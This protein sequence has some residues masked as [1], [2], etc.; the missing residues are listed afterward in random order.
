MASFMPVNADAGIY[1]NDSILFRE[2]MR[3]YLNNFVSRDPIYLFLLSSTLKVCGNSVFSGRILSVIMGT[4]SAIF[5]YKFVKMISGKKEAIASLFIYSFYPFFMWWGAEIKTEYTSYFFI[6]AAI[7]FLVKGYLKYNKWH[8]LMGGVMGALAHLSRESFLAVFFAIIFWLIY[9]NLFVVKNIRRCIEYIFLFSLS[10]FFSLLLISTLIYGKYIFSK[11]FFILVLPSL[12][13]WDFIVP[14][15]RGGISPPSEEISMARKILNNLWRL[16]LWSIDVIKYFF[17]YLFGIFGFI[18]LYLKI[19]KTLFFLLTLY[20]ISTIYTVIRVKFSFLIPLQLVSFSIIAVYLFLTTD[21]FLNLKKGVDSLLLIWI[22]FLFLGYSFYNYNIV[23][24]NDFS[25]PISTMSGIVISSIS[26]NSLFKKVTGI[27]FYTLCFIQ[28]ITYF[29]ITGGGDPRDINLQDAKVVAKEIKKIVPPDEEI[30]TADYLVIFL[31]ERK[32][33]KK[34]N[35]PY[36]Y[37]HNGKDFYLFYQYSLPPPSLFIE[38]VEKEASFILLEPRCTKWC[39]KELKLDEKI[40]DNFKEI[41]S[42]K[43]YKILKR[44]NRLNL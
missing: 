42:Y 38:M 27:I 8:L 14:Y 29:L 11:N 15:L 22:L 13:K 26:L 20:L 39:Y 3:P 28:P 7:Y 16:R 12:T 9:Q 5:L 25:L 4:L 37:C 33:F 24:N 44:K 23:Y 30:F 32:P 35:N 10:Y 6:S 31:A 17:L 40:H 43:D 36:P 19:K 2:G 34:I 21:K 41:W 1:L 18:T